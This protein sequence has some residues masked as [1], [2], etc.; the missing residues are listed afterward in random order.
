MAGL[1]PTAMRFP[2]NQTWSWGGPPMRGR[3]SE[4]TASKAENRAKLIWALQG[5]R[6]NRPK[7]EHSERRTYDENLSRGEFQMVSE[8]IPRG[9]SSFPRTRSREARDRLN[10][11][12]ESGVTNSR[13]PIFCAG[14]PHRCDCFPAERGISLPA[15]TRQASSVGYSNSRK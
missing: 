13:Q 15:M 6:S 12:S 3:K 8:A 7:W 1:K 14:R 10:S 11:D 5:R 4:E 9:S 2:K